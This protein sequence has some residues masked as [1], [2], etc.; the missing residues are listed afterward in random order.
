MAGNPYH[1][2]DGRFTSKDKATGAFIDGNDVSLEEYE[3]IKEELKNSERQYCEYTDV[4]GK[5]HR[6]GS[7]D[8]KPDCTPYRTMRN[9]SADKGKDE[10]DGE[11]LHSYHTYPKGDFTKKL[12]K[13]CP[14]CGAVLKVDGTC[15]KCGWPASKQP[16]LMP[17][18]QDK[19]K[20]KKD[21][22]FRKREG[23]K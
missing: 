6:I 22:N 20:K 17:T 19:P 2:A 8:K 16:V 18:G 13:E 11:K 10:G 23:F 12:K 4:N 9:R 5:K 3:R 21:E 7:D 15:P 14:I 1:G